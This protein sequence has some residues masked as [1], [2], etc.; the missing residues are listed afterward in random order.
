MVFNQ[1]GPLYALNPLVNNS[2]MVLLAIIV[3]RL[4][5][6]SFLYL[7]NVIEVLVL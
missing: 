2:T 7:S 3:S 1:C 4:A 6:I 5:W